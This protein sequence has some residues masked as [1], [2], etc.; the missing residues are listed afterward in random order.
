MTNGKWNH[1]AKAPFA[2]PPSEQACNRKQSS[3]PARGQINTLLDI[4]T[5]S[6]NL[7]PRSWSSFFKKNKC[8]KNDKLLGES[9]VWIILGMCILSD[10]CLQEVQQMENKNR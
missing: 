6:A 2:L 9:R 10:I 4:L 1:P 5:F 8:D 7:K 3:A